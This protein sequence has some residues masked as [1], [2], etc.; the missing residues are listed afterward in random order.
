M[1]RSKKKTRILGDTTAASEKEN[2]RKA[3]EKL[4]R[5]VKVKLKSRKEQLPLLR[6]VSNV[7]DF[8]KDGKRYQKEVEEKWMRK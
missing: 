5:R 4:R 8:N 3:T 6:K 2:K 7:Y 1:S